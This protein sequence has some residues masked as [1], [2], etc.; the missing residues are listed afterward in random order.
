M[1]IDHKGIKM[2]SLLPLNWCGSAEQVHQHCFSS[3]Y[4]VT[5]NGRIFILQSPTTGDNYKASCKPSI[6]QCKNSSTMNTLQGSLPDPRSFDQLLLNI[7]HRKSFRI[8]NLWHPPKTYCSQVPDL[9]SSLR[10]T[11][12]QRNAK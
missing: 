9:P 1:N 6:S 3:S 2:N 12:S 8:G 4:Q 11:I 7:R 5:N 10:D